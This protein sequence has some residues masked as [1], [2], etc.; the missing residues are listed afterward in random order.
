MPPATVSTVNDSSAAVHGALPK[1]PGYGGAVTTEGNGSCRSLPSYEQHGIVAGLG[2]PLLAQP[3]PVP[4]VDFTSASSAQQALVPAGAGPPQHEFEG[5]APFAR[6]AVVGVV[7]SLVICCLLL[8]GG[9]SCRRSSLEDA[10]A[11]RWT[12]A[13]C[14]S[15]DRV[16]LQLRGCGLP[17]IPTAVKLAI[18]N[19]AANAA[20]TVA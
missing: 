1:L 6:P 13:P 16:G 19:I 11:R 20:K 9:D 12:Q 14:C 8:T 15:L 2:V 4:A 17:N 3:Q 7:C 5:D 10:T 18:T